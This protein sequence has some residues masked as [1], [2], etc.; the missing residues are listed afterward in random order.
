MYPSAPSSSKSS[1]N[2]SLAK[3]QYVGGIDLEHLRSQLHLLR[4]I[5]LLKTGVMVSLPWMHRLDGA[6]GVD[7][8]GSIGAISAQ[9]H[10]PGLTATPMLVEVH[11]DDTDVIMEMA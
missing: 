1:F 9:V 4:T 5:S 2:R 10:D 3:P 11:H 7:V 8:D 6:V